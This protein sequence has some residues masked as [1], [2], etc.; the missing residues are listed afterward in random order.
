[1]YRAGPNGQ[2]RLVPTNKRN[3]QELIIAKENTNGAKPG[4]LVIAEILPGR[5]F[6]L[7][8][9]KISERIDQTQGT[10]LIST[11]ALHEYDIPIEFTP[12]ALNEAKAAKAAPL[13]D[14]DDLR[15]IP[16]VTIDGADARDFDDAVWAE[17]DPNPTT[18]AAGT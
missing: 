11:I 14:R 12:E 5:P 8:H 10:Q 17:A 7:R 9:G 2:G 18:S 1:M 15:D 16:L 4:D 6:G 3:R 13:A